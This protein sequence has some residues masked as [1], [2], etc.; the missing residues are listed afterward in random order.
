MPAKIQLYRPRGQRKE[1]NKIPCV[2]IKERRGGRLRSSGGGGRVQDRE[3][4]KTG[5]SP[6]GEIG[7]LGGGSRTLGRRDD[8]AGVMTRGKISKG[9]WHQGQLARTKIRQGPKKEDERCEEGAGWE[10]GMLSDKPIERVS[11]IPDPGF[12]VRNGLDACV[13]EMDV[14]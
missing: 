10:E 1:A 9:W 4:K 13:G 11:V 8:R 12:A 14:A 5:P 6:L 7:R 2:C 3:K